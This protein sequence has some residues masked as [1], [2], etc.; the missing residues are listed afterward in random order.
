[1][2]QTHFPL[3]SFPLIF[4]DR[5]QL[6]NQEDDQTEPQGEASR[7]RNDS[8]DFKEA[9]PKNSYHL[10]SFHFRDYPDRADLIHQ[11]VSK[12]ISFTKEQY[13]LKQPWKNIRI[14]AVEA[15][16]EHVKVINNLILIPLPNYKRSGF[17]D[18][19]VLGLVSLS[20]G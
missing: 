3:K 5:Y 19:R 11:W 2:P 15:E 1:M 16:Y 14:V 13:G 8:K 10:E 6:L 12:F 20:L 4:S 7:D 18:R 9:D 17:L